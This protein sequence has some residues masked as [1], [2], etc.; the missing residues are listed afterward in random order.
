M[1]SSKRHFTVIMNSKEHGLY[2]SSTPSSAARKA[3]SK[4]CADNKNKKV[5]FSVRET[6]QGSNK[7]V[8]GPYLGYM[9]KL[10]K[11]I[12]L[13]G[14]VIRYKPIAKLKKK[15]RKMKGG[16]IEILGEGKE[17]IVLRPNI[18]NPRN[19]DTVSKLITATPEQA[20][21]LIAFEEELNRIDKDGSY[22]VKM[23]SS[24]EISSENI[25]KIQNINQSNKN[26]MK[27]Y[28]F[29][30]T[31]QYGGISIQNF[32]G[33][34]EE[35]EKEYVDLIN[36]HFIQALLRG[37]L[38]CF[39]GIYE[40][41]KYGIA[42]SDLHADNIVFLL[43]RPEI[44]RMID[45]GILLPNTPKISTPGSANNSSRNS[46]LL[47]SSSS[48]PNSGN[49]IV[50]MGNS[51]IEF[52][53]GIREL[54]NQIKRFTSEDNKKILTDFFD[55]LNSKKEEILNQEGIDLL[56]GHMEKLIA[57]IK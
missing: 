6:T 27:K 45:W 41:Y 36:P 48:A 13:K 35:N 42:H 20:A 19:R 4:L 28:N 9:Q 57:T 38:H 26:R 3:V 29:K 23:L 50:R 46:H 15:S 33:K 32:M 5:E 53:A 47:S 16:V 18:N 17:G 56:R 21:E 34:L 12:E 11:P 51:L 52:S 10:D 43:N 14:R 30:I 49:L 22:H 31:Y 40:F 44:M 39:L 55:S 24:I 8:Y 25:N 2:V 1:S 54:F 7:K 37:I